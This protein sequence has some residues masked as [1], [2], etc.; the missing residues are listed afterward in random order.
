MVPERFEMR[1]V[2]TSH[3]LMSNALVTAAALA[4]AGCSGGGSSS[5]QVTPGV[6]PTGSNTG[7]FNGAVAGLAISPPGDLVL[8]S[9]SGSSLGQTFQIVV[10]VYD[11]QDNAMDYT[12]QVSYDFDDTIVSVNQQG[13]IT[14]VAPGQ[15]DVTV[16][17]QGVTGTLTA[18]KSVTVVPAPATA[19]QPNYVALAIYPLSR[20]LANVDQ[21][22]GI[23]QTQQ[24]VVVA[25]DDSGRMWDLTRTDGAQVLNY[26]DTSLTPLPPS[27]AGSLDPNGVFTGSVEGENVLLMTRLDQ[28]GLVAGSHFILGSGLAKP[29]GPGDLF[30]GGGLLGSS[31]PIDVALLSELQASG[32]S[33]ADASDDGEFLRRLYSDA[34]GRRATEAE[35]SAFLADTAANKRDALIDTLVASP[36]FAAHWGARL[37]EFLQIPD[38]TFD[39]WAADQI[40]AGQ[41]LRQ[42]FAGIVDGTSQG[43]MLFDAQHATVD[44]KVDVLGQVALGQTLECAKCHDHPVSGVN[45]LPIDSLT[46]DGLQDT[47]YGIDAFFAENADDATK[48]DKFA[49]RVGNPLQPSWLLE[50]NVTV[51]ST[52]ATP[53]ADRRAELATIFTTSALFDRGLAQ[54]LFA[55]VVQPIVNVNETFVADLSGALVPNTMAAV[56]QAFTDAN[57]DLPAFMATVFTSGTYQLS[58]SHTDTQYDALLARHVPRRDHSESAESLVLNMTGSNP[59]LLGF[60]RQTFGYP[61]DRAVVDERVDSVNMSQS[62]VFMNSSSVQDNVSDP[63][64]RIGQLAA[65]VD[66]GVITLDAALTSLFRTAYSRD[67]LAAEL[68][69]ANQ[70]VALAT[71][72]SEGLED[73][74][75]ALMASI[76]AMAH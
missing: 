65:D 4:F 75:T 61:L 47:R 3:W 10:D 14:A 32:A 30:D 23:Q 46:F 55:E 49:N 6:A 2:K 17:M 73:V 62:L 36:E 44:L 72:T 13:Q 7:S 43:G 54:R 8:N 22:G 28:Y 48:L 15:T 57:G 69:M 1:Q 16:T 20:T 52:D 5:Y 66:G 50:P 34:L 38:V 37:G 56:T 26:N 25:T 53:L 19:A 58:A 76:E 42:I 45:D 41:N 60:F 40:A 70:S 68:T 27:T 33:P 24:I 71:T 11:S 64:G 31:N 9:P 67:P 59:G 63:A 18:T 39:S 12:D 51:T 74:A 21:A 35:V 29:V